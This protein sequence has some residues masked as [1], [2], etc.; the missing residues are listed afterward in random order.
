MVETFSSVPK[1]D[2]SRLQDPSTK[3]DELLKLRKAIFVVGFLYLTDTGLEVRQ[4]SDAVPFPEKYIDRMIGS[5]S[6]SPRGT[7]SPFCT[8]IRGEREMQHDKLSVLPWIY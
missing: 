4:M 7:A 5:F 1:V 8:A 2:Y 3:N 6:S